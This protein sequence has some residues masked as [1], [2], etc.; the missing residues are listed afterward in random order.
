MGHRKQKAHW[1]WEKRI[2]RNIVK[3]HNDKCVS[4]TKGN[5]LSKSTPEPSRGT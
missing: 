4:G 3:G 5:Q 2:P 1:R